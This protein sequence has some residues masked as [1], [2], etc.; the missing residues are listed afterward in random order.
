MFAG[1]KRKRWTMEEENDLMK[2]FKVHITEKRNPNTKEIKCAM[3]KYHSLKERSEAVI[4][5]K[6]NNIILGKIKM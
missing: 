6:I 2:E 1:F 3:K 4:R 5:S